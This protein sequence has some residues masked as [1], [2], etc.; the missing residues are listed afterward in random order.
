M[1]EFSLKD[2]VGTSPFLFHI[3]KAC[4]NGRFPDHSHDFSELVIILGGTGIHRID[5]FEHFA[6]AGDIH[7]FNPGAVHGFGE[8]DNLSMCN[9]SYNAELFST[10]RSDVKTIPGFQSLFILDAL[11]QGNPRSQTFTPA[12]RLP[13]H[14]LRLAE[15]MI[16]E[17]LS[18]FEAR[19]EGYESLLV[20]CFL[21][22]VV[23]LSRNYRS[24]DEDTSS[25]LLKLAKAVS[26]IEK[27]FTGDIS[28]RTLCE[29]SGLSARHLSR[30]FV[31][32]YGT[33]PVEYII[34][35]RLEYAAG[36]LRRG[37]RPVTD[38]AYDSG[39]D[40]SNYFSRRFRQFFGQSPS[41]YRAVS[42]SA[43]AMRT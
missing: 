19:R 13:I 20:G 38:I 17:M 27:S 10:L 36:L 40:D 24:P 8:A 5:K 2:T 14:E 16:D 18:E 34:R 6:K 41:E 23:F 4:V 12:G 39:F 43:K 29:V 22:L 30:L 3:G 31:R 37:Q 9:I 42:T 21:K 35:T 28:L 25:S 1:K 11:A 15:S 26:M 7:V 33:S 32:N